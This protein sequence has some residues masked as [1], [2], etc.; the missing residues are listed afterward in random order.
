M[1]VRALLLRFPPR[2]VTP[3]LIRLAR[4]RRRARAGE[5]GFTLLEMLVAVLVLAALVSVVPRSLVAARTNI[6]RSK[7][8]LAAR[9]VA[10]TV[11]NE[12]LV[13]TALKPGAIGGEVDGR[14]WHATLTRIDTPP[15][16][17]GQM[18]L[19][20]HVEVT[21]SGS[22]TLDVDTMRVGAPQ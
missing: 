9:L 2:R 20:V 13:G 6:E 12:A 10:E 3:A 14:R 11:L 7:D 1:S 19:D 21:V 17:S 22:Q 15:A 8:R 18:L 4:S 5:A 16:Q